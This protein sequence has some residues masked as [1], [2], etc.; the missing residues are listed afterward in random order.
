MFSNRISHF[1]D[2][3]G[4]SMTIDTGCSTSTVALHQAVRNLQLGESDMSI[5]GSACA[6]LNPDVF[7]VMSSHG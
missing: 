6:L 7:V 1:F 3:H 2:L 5:V 4:A